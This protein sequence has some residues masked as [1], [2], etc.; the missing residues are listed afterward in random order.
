MQ[1]FSGE[2]GIGTLSSSVFI[3]NLLDSCVL[4][5]A[6]IFHLAIWRRIYIKIFKIVQNNWRLRGFNKMLQ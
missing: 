4:D 5:D 2:G 6:P 1:I 3:F